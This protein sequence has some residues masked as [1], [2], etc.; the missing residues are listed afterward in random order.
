MDTS[1]APSPIDNVIFE[2]SACFIILH[3]S[4]FYFGE[5][6]QAITASHVL[7]TSTKISLF[8]ITPINALASIMIA[9]FIICFLY[10]SF[11]SRR[12]GTN[13]SIAY[14]S[15]CTSQ[16]CISG[17]ISLQENPIFLAVSNLSPVSIHTLIF[18]SLKL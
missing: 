7:A 2:R 3:I 4:A 5:I 15:V 12:E 13:N 8:Y 16:I 18:A 11:I 6:L 17:L 9:H 14:S 1:L 10:L